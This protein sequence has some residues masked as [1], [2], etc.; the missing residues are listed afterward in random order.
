MLLSSFRQKDIL[1]GIL[2]VLLERKFSKGTHA[3]A[4]TVA[5]SETTAAPK[6]DL[7]STIQT[8]MHMFAQ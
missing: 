4:I 8:Q 7:I 5:S 2:Q 1:P 3:A 6:L